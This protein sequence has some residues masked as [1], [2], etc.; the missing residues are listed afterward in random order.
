MRYHSIKWPKTEVKKVWIGG[1]FNHYN[2]IVIFDKEPVS[3]DEVHNYIDGVWYD[4]QDNN[5]NIIGCL[6]M[7]DFIE[8]YPSVDISS[9]INKHGYVKNVEVTTLIEMALEVPMHNDHMYLAP[10]SVD[11]Y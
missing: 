3:S 2:A 7:E 11:G 5:K 10:M 6:G 1:Y 4:L 9:L 8:L